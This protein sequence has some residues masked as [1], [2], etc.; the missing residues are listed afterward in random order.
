MSPKNKQGNS[1]FPGIPDNIDIEY[2]Y[3]KKEN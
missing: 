3:I 1:I 2:V